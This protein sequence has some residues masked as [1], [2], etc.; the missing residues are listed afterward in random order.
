MKRRIATL[1]A[2][3]LMLSAPAWANPPLFAVSDF[4]GSYSVKQ[5]GHFNASGASVSISRIGIIR[6][7]GLGNL[8]G[9]SIDR[10]YPPQSTG[11][12]DPGKCAYDFTGTYA[13]SFVQLSGFI[14]LTVNFTI[15]PSQP[16][17]CAPTKSEVWSG[18]LTNPALVDFTTGG[19]SETVGE[20][21]RQ[22]H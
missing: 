18:V 16:A 14:W 11:G 22:T 6:P 4:Q 2:A 8:I 7:D 10:T 12:T 3:I 1:A 5:S 15:E 20:I 9:S 21:K 13:V 19:T 17:Y